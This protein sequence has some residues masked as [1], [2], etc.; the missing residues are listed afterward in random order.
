MAPQLTGNAQNGL[1]W[2]GLFRDEQA[3]KLDLYIR[4]ARKFEIDLP[5]PDA[6]IG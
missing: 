4:A 2:R 5:A 1:E 3:A 6:G